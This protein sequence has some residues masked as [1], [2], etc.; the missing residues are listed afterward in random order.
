MIDRVLSHYD[1]PKIIGR[2]IKAKNTNELLQRVRSESEQIISLRKRVDKL[3]VI[4]MFGIQEAFGGGS[5]KWNILHVKNMIAELDHLGCEIILMKS[6]IQKKNELSKGIVNWITGYNERISKHPGVHLV[7]HQIK[8]MKINRTD[9][10]KISSRIASVL[11]RVYADIKVGSTEKTE[12]TKVPVVIVKRPRKRNWKMK[13]DDKINGE[14]VKIE[15]QADKIKK[16]EPKKKAKKSKKGIDLN[17]TNL[18]LAS[19]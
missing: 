16:E 11:K 1:N 7:N 8:D 17:N 14:Q 9:I 3:F 2:Q 19:Y 5:V 12:K 6:N 13:K 4:G 15:K 10:E 18:N